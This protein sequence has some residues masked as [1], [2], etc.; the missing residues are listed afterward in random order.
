LTF[1]HHLME[2]REVMNI[3]VVCVHVA[4]ATVLFLLLSWLGR[5]S[6]LLGYMTL[7]A[8]VQADAAP[9]FNFLFRVVGPMVFVILS[10]TGLY[11]LGLDR[12]VASIWLVAAYYCFARLAYIVILDRIRLV[13][14]PREFFIWVAMIGGTWLI[15]RSVIS[16]REYLLPEIKDLKNQFWI[17]LIL[18]VFTAFNNIRLRSD[19]TVARKRAY[20]L[21]AYSSSRERYG[22]LISSL[23]RDE[24]SES[25]VYSV[26][27]YEQFNRPRLVQLVERLVF[28]VFSRTLGPMQVATNTRLTDSDSVRLGTERV[29]ALYDSAL[30][31]GAKKAADKGRQ[32]EPA[33]NSS[34]RCYVIYR[35]ASGYNKDDG[36]LADMQEMHNEVVALRYPALQFTAP[37]WTEH[38]F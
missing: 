32:F 11:S 37:H 19:E 9:A 8:F 28:P 34:H 20:L 36:Y 22:R 15:Y 24:L 18:F 21:G 31:E 13:N 27:I 4:L 12:Y 17:L 16:N 14:W 3:D 33:T 35:V 25:I 6:L 1:G 26:L 2:N 10:A 7:S 5:H 29:I 38:L 30:N 23:V